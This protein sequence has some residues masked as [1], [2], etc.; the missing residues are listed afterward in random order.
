MLS[1]HPRDF[2]A[3]AAE[4]EAQSPSQVEEFISKNL[5]PDSRMYAAWDANERMAGTIGYYR[6]NSAKRVHVREIW[7]MYVAPTA[8]RCGLGRALIEH[9]M[10]DLRQLPGVLRVNIEVSAGNT[11]ARALYEATGFE[12][13]GIEPEGL[14]I[15]EHLEDT[16]LMS[17]R[18]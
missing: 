17:Q 5:G 14:Q 11:G 3:D 7:G 6:E 1:E 2:G 16:V 8:R 12:V 13:Y 15:G 10:D 18:L 9:V 4:F